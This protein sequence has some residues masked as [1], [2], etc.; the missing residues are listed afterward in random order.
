MGIEI[1]RIDDRLVH[2]QIVQGWLKVVDVN[3]ILVVSDAVALDEMQQVLLSMAV[4]S[5]IGFKASSVEVA[6]ADILN[7]VY[8]D[9][10]VMALFSNPCDIVRVLNSGVKLKSVNIGGMHYVHGKRQL[11]CNLSVDDRDV[12]CLAD[13]YKRGIELEGRLLPNDDRTDLSKIIIE[14]E[15]KINSQGTCNG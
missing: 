3:F 12:F 9:K 10:K 4:P 5:G 1:V 11:L 6:S 7:N 14:E 8:E 15:N 2:G 13:I